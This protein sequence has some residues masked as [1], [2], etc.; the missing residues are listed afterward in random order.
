VPAASVQ[1]RPVP[2]TLRPLATAEAFAAAFG[3]APVPTAY[4]LAAG[5]TR[6]QLRAALGR[7]L[8]VSPRRGVVS[9]PPGCLPPH[10]GGAPRTG[11]PQ[12]GGL[13]GPDWRAH[14]VSLV[15]AALVAVGAGAFATHDSAAAV[16]AGATPDPR[17]P[18]VVT[19][20]RPGIQDFAGPG[21]VVRGSDIPA[22][23]VTRV[24]GVPVTDL[25]RTAVD[26]ARGRSLPSAL[27]PLDHAAR[28]LVAA[29]TR[30][31]GPALRREVLEPEVRARA[32]RELAYAV[33]SCR[34]WPGVASARRA[35]ALTDPASESPLESRSRGWFLMAGMELE[36]GARIEVDGATYWADFC[37]RERRVIGEA[38]GWS[39]YGADGA[40]VRAALKA[41]RARQDRLVAAGWN[42]VRW[43]SD[44]RSAQVVS[45][46]RAALSRG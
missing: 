24:D 13:V 31:T 14:H 20:A 1:A 38:D 18:E 25:R 8:L 27:I 5:F 46:M 42:V 15:R 12:G 17:P 16:L 7:G 29:A 37:D 2:P 44:D 6:E 39:K 36:I 19:L 9:L 4:A 32:L 11:T 33:A 22:H 34:G 45:R 28:R 43:T 41:E 30:T 35:L 10:G 21:L 3:A 26:L 23:F 40:D